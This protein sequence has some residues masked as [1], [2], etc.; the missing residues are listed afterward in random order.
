MF[1]Y[2][3]YLYPLK[4]L[5]CK[6]KI[7]FPLPFLS[8]EKDTA[9]RSFSVLLINRVC[10]QPEW[11][12]SYFVPI[13]TILRYFAL[14]SAL[15]LLSPSNLHFLWF[16]FQLPGLMKEQELAWVHKRYDPILHLFPRVLS[17]AFYQH[18][19]LQESFGLDDKPQVSY[20]IY[21]C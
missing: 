21:C 18:D 19:L 7:V 11:S 9:L 17:M 4:L 13:T 15:F 8:G 3:P 10:R 6:Q 12:L 14:V 20:V 16:S 5:L 1:P 2:V